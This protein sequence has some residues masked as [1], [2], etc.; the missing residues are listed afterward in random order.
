MNRAESRDE[1]CLSDE[2]II[3][4][5][6]KRQ[7]QAIAQTDLKYGRYLYKIAYNI[8][9][10]HP[11]SEECL[12]DTYLGTWNRIPPARPNVFQAF[13]SKIMR[14]VAVDKFRCNSAKRKIPSSLMTSIEEL[15]DCVAYEPSVEETYAIEE[16][17][18]ILNVYLH[19]LSDR[20]ATVFICR[21]YY[22]DPI[23]EIAKMLDVSER[24]VGRILLTLRNNL[25]KAL[26]KEGYGHV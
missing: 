6:W 19:S 18:R 9:H 13:L 21:Y 17:K 22:A 3:E 15:D 12:N 20:D 11:D 14:N 7:E 23:A 1:R 25:K 26:E 16:L 10:D 5:Y 24:T 8:V 4:L 2:E